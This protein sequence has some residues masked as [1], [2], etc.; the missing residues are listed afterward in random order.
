MIVANFLQ[1][2]FVAATDT[3]IMSIEWA[4]SEILRNPRVVLRKAQAEL[5][6]VV[7]DH[8]LVQESDLPHLKYIQC[9]CKE[10]LRLHPAAPLLLPHE[11]VDASRAFGYD[12]PAKCR[13]LVNAYAIG[14]DPKTWDDPLAFDPERFVQ[15]RHSHIDSHGQD[16]ELL[17]FG[18]GRRICP[19]MNTANVILQF[20]VAN[21]LH[22]FEWSLPAPMVPEDLDMS[23]GIGLTIPKRVPLCAT[24]KPRLSPTLYE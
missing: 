22:A 19:G 16:F 12:I 10:T 18:S 23:E 4:M 1:N 3:T 5:D 21:L 24:A 20:A 11:S 7:G 9:I 6:E 13:L 17:P 8:K 2:A 14:R 15:G